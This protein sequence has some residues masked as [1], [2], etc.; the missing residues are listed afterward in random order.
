GPSSCTPGDGWQGGY[1]SLWVSGSDQ[2]WLPLISFSP[3]GRLMVELS[4]MRVLFIADG[5]SPIARNWI[6]Y[7]L[8]DG[9][10]VH[11]ASTFACRPDPRLAS[12]TFIPV[13][14]SAAKQAAPP[15]GA[16]AAPRRAAP[17]WSAR[18][19]GLRTGVRQL[20]GPLTLPAAARRLSRLVDRLQPDLLHAMRIPFEG[21]LAAQARPRPPL[22]VSVWGNDFT[23]HAR[24]TPWMAALTRRTLR[25]AGALHADCRRDVRLAGE[26]GFAPGR[27][28][29][30]L[31]GAGG[32]QPEIFYP[33]SEPVR[34]PR[35][36]MPRGFRAYVDNRL[37]FHSLPGVAR[38]FPSLQVVCPAMAGERQVLDWIEQ[39][40]LQQH[41]ELLPPI[42]RPQMAELLR[43][44][45]A[46]VSP[47]THDGTPNTLLEGMACGCLPVAGD[48]ES[49]R[50]WITPGENGLLPALDGPSPGGDSPLA[51]AMLRALQDDALCDQAAAIN[52]R[53]VTERAAYPIVMA[54]AADFYRTI[55]A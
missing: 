10:E 15:P 28:S 47:A 54:A 7:F 41:V 34:R 36:V 6:D 9:W 8:A 48:L 18:L 50:E 20:L 45:R 32:L 53:L 26:W 21:M 44:A 2:R 55:S 1:P 23:L 46:V 40:G 30:V 12:Y 42:P 13:A 16:P 29:I 37:F 11:L 19:V 33:P 24:S 27:P 22:L 38:W 4:P 17:L 25:A 51:Q 31:P 43:G 49:L 5:R 14:F 39:L 3:A 35:L 52:R